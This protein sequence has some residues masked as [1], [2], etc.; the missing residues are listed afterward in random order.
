MLPNSALQLTS[1]LAYALVLAAERENIRRTTVAWSMNKRRL[2]WVLVVSVAFGAVPV[3]TELLGLGSF[4]G[5]LLFLLALFALFAAAVSGVLS[6]L[7]VNRS[8]SLSIAVPCA[9]FA[10]VGLC[11]TRLSWTARRFAF[12]RLAARSVPVIEAIEAYA[13]ARGRPPSTL[14]DLVPAYL[15]DFPR[16]GMPAYPDYEYVLFPVDSHAR[17]Y[18]YDLGP[19]VRRPVDGLWSLPVGD[20]GHSVL[21]F[22]ISL[23]GIIRDVDVQRPGN[24]TEGPFDTAS[25]REKT[26]ARAEM[27]GSL[28]RSITPLGKTMRDVEEVLGLPDGERTLRESEWE[29]RVPCSSGAMTSDEFFYLPDQHYGGDNIERIGSW[30]YLHVTL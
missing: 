7:P 26:S 2:A 8:V 14:R 17:L 1:P 22:A 10:L 4:G 3:V 11:F 12:S 24:V 6:L 30:A 25:W 5:D 21:V 15:A 20:N 27:V 19:G 9:V 23:D 29:L 13:R 18:W 16:T 28:V